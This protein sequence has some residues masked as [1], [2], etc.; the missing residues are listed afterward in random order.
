MSRTVLGPYR[1]A[2]EGFEAVLRRV[3]AGGWD[4]PS[5]CELWTVRDVAGH[6]IWGQ[7]QLAHWATGREYGRIDGAPGAPHPAGLAGSDPLSTWRTA[8]TAADDTLTADALGRTV[9]LPGLGETPLSGIVTLLVT[10]LLAH[11]W[12]I[13][14]ALGLEVRLE[15]D[16]VSG[17]FAWARDNVIRVPGFF[18]PELTSPAH[19][20]EQTRWLAYLGRVA[21]APAHA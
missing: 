13:G 19:A 17:S 6:V 11:S 12:D 8:R 1:R 14:H 16:L 5:E 18:G 10:D 20:D 9:T 3:P 4:A 21:S 2:Q 7:E 15:P